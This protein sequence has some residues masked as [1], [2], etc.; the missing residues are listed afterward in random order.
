MKE[1]EKRKNDIFLEMTQSASY[2]ISTVH[3]NNKKFNF[4]DRNMIILVPQLL[5]N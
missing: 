2:K 4:V 5:F 3:T 1:N